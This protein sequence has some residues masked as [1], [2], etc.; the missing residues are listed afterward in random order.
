M[1]TCIAI[2]VCLLHKERLVVNLEIYISYTGHILQQNFKWIIYMPR[3]PRLNE[4]WL[5]HRLILGRKHRMTLV[6]RHCNLC[7][8]NEIMVLCYTYGL[9]Q[10][11]SN[12]IFY[13]MESPQSCTK[14]S[15]F[16]YVFLDSGRWPVILIEINFLI[17]WRSASLICICVRCICFDNIITHITDL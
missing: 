5:H 11:C 6:I 16:R 1:F 3:G 15:I 17:E 2:K 8:V 10:D 4:I 13:A 12:S 9:V 7:R 14:P